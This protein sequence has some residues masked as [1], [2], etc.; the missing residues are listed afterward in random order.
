MNVDTVVLV[1]ERDQSRGWTLYA[2]WPVPGQERLVKARTCLF[3]G[4]RPIMMRLCLIGGSTRLVGSEIEAFP[5]SIGWELV[6]GSC[7]D[8]RHDALEFC[9]VCNTL[10][11]AFPADAGLPETAERAGHVHVVRVHSYCSGADGSCDT[12]ASILITR[13]DARFETVR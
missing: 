7:A 11:T 5:G 13:P 2:P 12:Y 4:L 8:R 9:V 1:L 3:G 6:I 10:R